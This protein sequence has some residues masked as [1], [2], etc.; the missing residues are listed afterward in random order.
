MDTTINAGVLNDHW[1]DL[2][3]W[4]TRNVDPARQFD[5]WRDFVVDAH[6]HWDIRAIPCD[7]FPAFIRQGRFGG[8]RLVHLTAARGG[9]IG[10]RTSLQIQQDH[11][12]LYNLIYVAEGS[13]TL[14]LGGDREMHLGPGTFGLWDST[15][16]MKFNTG[17][18]L[19]QV[20]F[21]VP[22]RR[23]DEALPGCEDLCGHVMDAHT[24]IGKLF[25]DC[26]LA[27]ES[28]FGDLS[29]PQASEVLEAT[30]E[31]L[32]ATLRAK[33]QPALASRRPGDP[34]R[35]ILEAIDRQLDDPG[36]T[37]QRVAQAHGLS[38][39][40]LYRLFAEAQTKPAA[41]IRRRR[42]ERCRHDLLSPSSRH[43]GVLDIAARWGFFDA[44]AFCRAFRQA[45]GVSPSRLRAQAGH[46]AET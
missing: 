30:T 16:P 12:A 45:Y 15:E 44:S 18:G 43:R 22:R 41:W 39:R 42:L 9:V 29:A 35:P 25:I 6:L 5:V 38:E 8:Y 20:T 40:Q 36:L 19:R 32:V 28:S 31:L 10:R 46:R 37:P 1:R 34:L 24:G 21:S 3:S 2:D 14:T 27:L 33:R 26:M 23:L 7:R 17:E 4:T 11:E 13:Q